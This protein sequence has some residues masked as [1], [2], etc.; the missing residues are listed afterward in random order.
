MCGTE[1]CNISWHIQPLQAELPCNPLGVDISLR[2]A[3]SPSS[4]A[5]SWFWTQNVSQAGINGTQ[6]LPDVAPYTVTTYIPGFPTLLFQVNEFTV[7][8]YWCEITD[9]GVDVK[10]SAIA[11]IVSNCLLPS[12]SDPYETVPH[13]FHSMCALDSVDDDSVSSTLPATNLPVVQVSCP[14]P[15]AS[16]ITTS[17]ELHSTTPLMLHHENSTVITSS[18]FQ[19]RTLSKNLLV[20]ESTSVTVQA[21]CTASPCSCSEITGRDALLPWVVAGALGTALIFVFFLLFLCILINC[22]LKR[23]LARLKESIL[24]EGKAW[25][26]LYPC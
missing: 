3:S 21:E 5:V 19:L 16:T 15:T 20:H 9:A 22:R 17:A 10:P 8:Y 11:P 1:A 23:K 26:I 25:S 2:C 4:L 14:I 13:N 6:I 18:E 24:G 12:C 7:G